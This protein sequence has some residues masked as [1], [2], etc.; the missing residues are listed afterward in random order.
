MLTYNT[1][2]KPLAMPE[3]GRNLQQMVDHCM[4]IEDREERNICARSIIRAMEQL[5]PELKLPENAHKVWD[6]LAIMSDFKLDI[7]YPEDVVKP[8][9]LKTQPE[10]VPY[11][12]SDIRHRHYGK[13]T[14][15]MVGKAAAMESGKERDAVVMLLANHMKKQM[16][17]L[18]PD[19]V[20]DRKIFTDLAVMSGGELRLDPE[21]HRLHQ[22]HEL[23]KP[24]TGKKKKK[25]K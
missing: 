18:S 22:F 20:D 13:I 21:T 19:G 2:L 3:Y 16:L 8:E 23:P 7:D 5:F 24:Q 6:H 25:R 11:A 14:S 4:T 1:M 12:Q 9:D 10:T 15:Q 17:A